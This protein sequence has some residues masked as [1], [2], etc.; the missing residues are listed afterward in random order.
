MC[1]FILPV[2]LGKLSKCTVLPGDPLVRSS[3]PFGLAYAQTTN[4][5]PT[6]EK[7]RDKERDV[8]PVNKCSKAVDECAV[9]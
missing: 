5:K 1:I 7:R 2:G 9:L 3:L 4:V 6:T 8:E